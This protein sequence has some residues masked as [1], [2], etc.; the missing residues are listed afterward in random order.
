MNIKRLSILAFLALCCAT[1]ATAQGGWRQW[2]IYLV[3]GTRLFATPLGM[4][5]KGRFTYYMG[6]REGT[7]RTKISHIVIVADGLPPAPT[8]KIKQDLIV[9]RDG[10]KSFGAITFKELKFSEGILIQNGKEISTENIAYIKFAPPKKKK[11]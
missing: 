3:D 7:E 6:D 2:N 4:N 9:F 8:E 5:E 1:S 10:T 11:Y